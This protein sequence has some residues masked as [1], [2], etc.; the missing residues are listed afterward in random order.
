ML[1]GLPLEQRRGPSRGGWRAAN[2]LVRSV[3]AQ[4]TATSPWAGRLSRVPGLRCSAGYS[5]ARAF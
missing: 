2:A 4:R 1:E 5:R 3:L